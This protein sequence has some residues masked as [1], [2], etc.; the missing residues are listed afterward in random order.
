MTLLDTIVHGFAKNAAVSSGGW[1]G[2]ATARVSFAK[3][4]EPPLLH[5]A[6]NNA[7]PST[8]KS[9][10]SVAE[11][12]RPIGTPR[13]CICSLDACKYIARNYVC[14]PLCPSSPHISVYLPAS[15]HGCE[16][17]PLY[18]AA[19]VRTP[20]HL[21]LVTHTPPARLP[22]AYTYT[23]RALGDSFPPR[24]TFWLQLQLATIFF[25]Q[26]TKVCAF[27][28]LPPV[29]NLPMVGPYFSL[30]PSMPLRFP[31]AHDSPNDSP[32]SDRVCIP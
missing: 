19:I 9:S 3:N 10:R 29:V 25:L 5:L 1:G 12:I 18:V 16:I 23:V 13:R 27:L 20:I 22:L 2:A 4:T 6:L 14:T 32:P 11:H 31:V 15:A 24:L 28:E 26:K 7:G 21:P 17:M 30:P 8:A